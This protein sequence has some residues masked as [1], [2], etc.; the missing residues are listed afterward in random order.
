M[1]S[2][3]IEPQSGDE[4][5]PIRHEA[6]MNVESTRV[7]SGMIVQVL[8]AGFMFREQVLRPAKVGDGDLTDHA[9][10]RLRL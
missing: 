6:M 8:Q 1:E 9:D 7:D 4:F 2:S 10:L 3:R 5:D